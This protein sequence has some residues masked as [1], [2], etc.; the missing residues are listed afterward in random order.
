MKHKLI[1]SLFAGI[2]GSLAISVLLVCLTNMNL[3]GITFVM[4]ITY[5]AIVGVTS[6]LMEHFESEQ[7]ARSHR[8]PSGPVYITLNKEEWYH[9]RKAS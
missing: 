6:S 7:Q 8:R 9:G 3:G 2:A 5:F 1:L 4:L